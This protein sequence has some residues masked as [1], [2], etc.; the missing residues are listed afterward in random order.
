TAEEGAREPE[1]DCAIC[2]SRYDNTFR[3]PKQLECQHSF[4]LECLARMSLAA[5]AEQTAGRL[6]C[7]L[8]RHPTVLDTGQLITDLPTNSSILN[9]L[10]LEPNHIILEDGRLYYKDSQKSR[11]FLR[12]P[13]IYTLSL[14][15]ER[16]LAF[17]QP[18]NQVHPRPPATTG[19]GSFRECC[20]SP[21]FRTFTY[22]MVTMFGITVLLIISLFWTRQLLW[23][24]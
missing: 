13:T 4:C 1:A 22:V 8:C 21:Q 16:G 2:W 9:Q 5:V 17:R 19:H 15:V 20:R 7:P 6:P 10:K 23:G 3:T 14:N 12:Q 11:F 24:L 18:G